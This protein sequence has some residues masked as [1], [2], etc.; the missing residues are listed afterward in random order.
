M[1]EYNYLVNLRVESAPDKTVVKELNRRN[2]ERFLAFADD[3]AIPI[4]KHH[5]LDLVGIVSVRVEDTDVALLE[6]CEVVDC[7]NV[8]GTKS[9]C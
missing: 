2:L 5:F 1:S 6:E 7:I 8:N 9:T 4:Y 3:K